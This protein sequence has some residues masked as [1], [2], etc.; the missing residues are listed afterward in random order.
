MCDVYDEVIVGCF[1]GVIDCD[2]VV[3]DVYDFVV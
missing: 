2:V 1:D 3:V